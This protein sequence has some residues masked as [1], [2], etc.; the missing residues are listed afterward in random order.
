MKQAW[1][2]RGFLAGVGVAV[3]ASCGRPPELEPEARTEKPFELEEVSLDAL[4]QRMERGELTA[5]R[6]VEL[7]LERIEAVD[8]RLHSVIEINPDARAIAAQLD[9]ERKDG[10]VRGPLHGAPI[11]IKDNIDTADKMQTTAGSLALEGSIAARD[12]AV[13]ERLREAGAVILGKTNLSEWANFRSTNSTSGWSGRGGLTHNPYVLDRNACGSS[14]GSGAAA[15]A[16]LCAAA[17]GTET[18]GSIVCPSSINGLVGIK[19]TLGLVAQAGIIPIAHTQ[20]TAGPMARTVLDAALLLDALA[21]PGTRK[22]DRYAAFC[23]AGKLKG[24]RIG[25]AR[26]LMGRRDDADK[27]AEEAI[28]ALE[29]EGAEVVDIEGLPEGGATGDAGYQVLLYEFKADLN[30]YLAG[31]GPQARVK[32]L[33]EVIAFNETNADREMPYFGQEHMI[34]AEEKGG[35]DSP[36]YKKALALTKRMAQAQGIDKA[37]D[38]YKLDAILAPTTGPSW[39][40]DLVNG[41]HG[42]GGSSSLAARAGYPNITVPMGLIHGLPVGVSFFGKAWTEPRLIEIAYGYEQ[43]TKQRRPPQLIPSLEA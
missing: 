30:K 19:P 43:A 34:R 24:A 40:T 6:A 18:N 26:Q 22:E 32:S 20:D 28:A 14:S 27:L 2:R 35:L 9:Q 29:A 41:D 25:V 36:E 8:G 37:V 4:R 42:S 23:V 7:Y 11:L 3:G 31:L 21:D 12:S 10:K 17:V 5:E 15:S 33:A 1:T 16:S 39:T 13:A 38:R